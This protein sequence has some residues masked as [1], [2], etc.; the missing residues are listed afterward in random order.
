MTVVVGGA[1]RE[2]CAEPRVHWTFGSGVRAAAVLGETADR[3]VTVADGRT[4]TAIGAVIRVQHVEVTPRLRPIEFAYDTSLSR[5][6]LLMHNADRD[7]AMP[8]VDA[9]DAIV[10]GMV[11]ARPSVSAGRAVVDPQ[12][13]LSLDDIAETINASE[14][15]IVANQR[16]IYALASGRDLEE[17]VEAIIGCT[18]AAGVIVKA[19]ALGAL[20]FRKGVEVTGIPAFVTPRVFPIG[21]GDVFTAAFAMHYFENGDLTAAA[22]YASFRTAGYTTVRHHRPVSLTNEARVT[23][24]PTLQSVQNPPWVYVAAS[25]ANPE[26]R[27]SGRTIDRG[28]DDIGGRS[29]YPLR[30]VGEKEHAHVHGPSRPGESG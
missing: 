16:E 13:S 10:F 4:R 15:F 9:D 14:L 1:Y 19:G 7:I 5:P 6:R 12:Q 11:E 18:G 22:H 24:A 25:F 30:E 2:V 28:I 20:V 21:S 3:L 26:Q 29:L 27:W 23:V 17:A 8:P